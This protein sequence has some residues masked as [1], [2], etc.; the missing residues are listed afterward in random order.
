MVR[1]WP[2][3]SFRHPESLDNTLDLKETTEPPDLEEGLADDDA[4]DENVPP[5]DTAVCALG[6][7]AVGAFAEDN[8]LLLVLDLGEE[9]G[10]ALHCS[11]C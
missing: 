9:L 1:K 2:S 3:F 4:N 10:E 6:G 8:V 7:V 11:G 5:L